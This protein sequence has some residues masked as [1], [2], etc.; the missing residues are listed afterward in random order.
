MA[1]TFHGSRAYEDRLRGFAVHIVFR[2]GATGQDD[3]WSGSFSLASARFWCEDFAALVVAAATGLGSHT[4]GQDGLFRL[5][6]GFTLTSRFL[7]IWRGCSGG[8]GLGCTWCFFCLVVCGHNG[9]HGVDQAVIDLWHLPGRETETSEQE[10]EHHGQLAHLLGVQAGTFVELVDGPVVAVWLFAQAGFEVERAAHQVPLVDRGKR[11][12]CDA[13]HVQMTA[14]EHVQVAVDQHGALRDQDEVNTHVAVCLKSFDVFWHHRPIGAWR[15][16]FLHLIEDD[17]A[18]GLGPFVPV[19]QAFVVAAVDE[20]VIELQTVDVGVDG[21][22]VERH[23]AV[24]LLGHVSAD[25]G[26]KQLLDGVQ[27]LSAAWCASDDGDHVLARI[28][29]KNLGGLLCL[30]DQ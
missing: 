15:P 29:A 26:R 17:D 13:T 2:E 7:F 30:P 11:Q 9:L 21:A 5:S 14:A 23:D 18:A 1:T 28:D 19:A 20:L 6:R 27:R 3:C 4:T 8:R 10:P 24:D 25:E 12:V 22:W 16:D